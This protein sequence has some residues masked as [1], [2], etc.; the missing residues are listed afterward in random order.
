M[1]KGEFSSGDWCRFCKA[2]NQ[3][4]ARAEKNLEIAKMEF[5][6]PDL[7]TDEEIVKVLKIADE[8]SKWASD[9]YTYAKDQAFVHGKKWPGFKLVEGRSN[10]KYVSEE[11]VADAAIAAGYEDIYKQSLI[12]ITAMEKL[13]GKKTFHKILSHLI[14]KPKGKITLVLETDKREAINNTTAAAE[15]QED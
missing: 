3:C 5:K 11:E 7:L 14:Y 4:R 1:G 6:M 13:M 12:T 10:R 9:V 8:L 2:R 15:F